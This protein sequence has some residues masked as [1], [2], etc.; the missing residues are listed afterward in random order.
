[1]ETL[2]IKIPPPFWGYLFLFLGIAIQYCIGKRKFDRRGIGGL[3]QFSSYG[4]A[5]IITFLEWLFKGI[6]FALIGLGLFLLINL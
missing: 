1:M 6:G 5:V 3:P 4:K 2:S